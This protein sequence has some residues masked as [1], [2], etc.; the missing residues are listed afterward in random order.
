MQEITKVYEILGDVDHSLADTHDAV[1]APALQLCYPFPYLLRDTMNS[2]IHQKNF[3]IRHF[4]EKEEIFLPVTHRAQA[5]LRII[6]MMLFTACRLR[7]QEH[8]GHPILDGT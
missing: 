5:A 4:F 3:F 8:E 7:Q 1:R 2:S 6:S